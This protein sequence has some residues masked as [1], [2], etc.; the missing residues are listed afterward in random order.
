MASSASTS[1]SAS[2]ARRHSTGGS[3]HLASGSSPSSYVALACSQGRG[4]VQP[5]PSARRGSSYANESYAVPRMQGN[6]SSAVPA[7]ASGGTP[8]KH[9]MASTW[10]A[11]FLPS[12]QR[13]IWHKGACPSRAACHS[14]GIHPSHP[15]RPF[16]GDRIVCCS[17]DCN[18]EWCAACQREWAGRRRG[19]SP[20]RE[21]AR[22]RPHSTLWCGRAVLPF[23]TL[24]DRRSARSDAIEAA[25]SRLAGCR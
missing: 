8:S 7:P 13:G 15:V 10:P 22:D 21:R 11:S 1:C 20:P 6:K 19:T 2:C 18:R 14:F 17:A 25:P 3:S 24:A 16:V 23:G 4:D 5:S 12:P 9:A